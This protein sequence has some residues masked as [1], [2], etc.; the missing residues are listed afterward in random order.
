MLTYLYVIKSGVTINAPIK[1]GVAINVE[2]RLDELQTGNPNELVVMYKIPMN[3][4]SH[5]YYTESRL[6]KQLNRYHIRGEW[7][8]HRAINKIKIKELLKDRE[9][10]KLFN[11]NDLEMICEANAHI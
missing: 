2:R 1:I 9:H 10:E 4:R 11:E 6:H 3:S 8:M 7:F 5:A